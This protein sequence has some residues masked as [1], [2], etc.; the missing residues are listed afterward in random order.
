LLEFEEYA[1]SPA[2]KL[3]GAALVVLLFI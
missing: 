2:A 1:I 3:E